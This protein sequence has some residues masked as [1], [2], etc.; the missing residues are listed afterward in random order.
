MPNGMT[1]WTFETA[2]VFIH[3][4]R[5]FYIKKIV[6][7]ETIK[8]KA[9]KCWDKVLFFVFSKSLQNYYTVYR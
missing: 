3:K 4:Y 5:H 1:G 9:I 2:C 7:K 8:E 6:Q